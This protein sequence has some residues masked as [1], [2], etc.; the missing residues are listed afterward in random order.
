MPKESYKN[1]DITVNGK[2]LQDCECITNGRRYRVRLIECNGQILNDIETR[3]VGKILFSID[4]ALTGIEL[5]GT[6]GSA[7]SIELYASDIGIEEDEYNVDYKYTIKDYKLLVSFGTLLEVTNEKTIATSQYPNAIN[8]LEGYLKKGSYVN[9]S[10][11]TP[12]G[13]VIEQKIELSADASPVVSVPYEYLNK[14]SDEAYVKI[15]FDFT[16]TYIYKS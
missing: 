2:A 4:F 15:P 1:L 14:H 3:F 10:I 6:K 7:V 5:Y 12:D 8:P 9:L 16:H 13:K 11:E